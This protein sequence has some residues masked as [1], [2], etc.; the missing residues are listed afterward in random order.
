MFGKFNWVLAKRMV[1]QR[2][3]GWYDVVPGNFRGDAALGTHT[4]LRCLAVA[5]P[6]AWSRYTSRGQLHVYG[7]AGFLNTDKHF[8]G[9]QGDYADIEYG[10]VGLRCVLRGH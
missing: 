7:D 8:V 1:I 4:K 6:E 9:R 3:N 2:A 5:R 10:S